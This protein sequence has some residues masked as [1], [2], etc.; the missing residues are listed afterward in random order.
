M[1]ILNAF[2]LSTEGILLPQ[3]LAPKIEGFPE[4]AILTFNEST[5]KAAVEAHGGDRIGEF[6]AGSVFPIYRLN[7]NG[8]HVAVA[9]TLIG[10]AGSAA[11][12]EEIISKGARKIIFFGSCG[13]LDAALLRG[14]LIIPTSAYR[15]E[16]TSY[17][18]APPE[19]D[20]IEIATANRLSEIFSELEIPHV[21]GRTWTTDALYRE[22]RGNTEKR[23]AEGCITV[24][25]ECAS[26]VA[27]GKFRGVEV[28]QFLYAADSLAGEEWD[29]RGV[30]I[31]LRA[32]RDRCMEI[33]LEVALKI[34]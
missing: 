8:K 34:Q 24:E 33:A 3:H 10:G 7:Y 30:A 22:T 14:H 28:Y 31:E 20:Y 6:N 18:Y 17:H 5:V 26:V 32:D 23:R 15:D 27:V 11:L 9:R 21:C 29:R 19:D 12:L 16:G 1:S 25:Q 4:V 13:A 2:D